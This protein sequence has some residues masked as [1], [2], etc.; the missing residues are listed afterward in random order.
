MNTKLCPLC[1]SGKIR[2]RDGVKVSK[3]CSNC[4]KLKEVEK[5]EKKKLISL[6]KV[7]KECEDLAK[8]IA[9]A[10]DKYICQMCDKKVEGSN[11]HGSHV[12]PVS[13]G[14][15]FRFDP[16]NIKCLCGNCHLRVWHK[17]P[18]ES[19]EWFKNKFPDRYDYL[20]GKPH[21]SVKFTRADY[22]EMIERYK[23]ILKDLTVK[24][25]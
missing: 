23:I 18:I 4:R 1:K 20:F 15:Q 25:D 3:H 7:R 8:K 14:N 2:L 10:R 17:N 21:E 13:H 6:T 5:K 19:S 11:A 16:M 12:V 24:N 9:K 22:D